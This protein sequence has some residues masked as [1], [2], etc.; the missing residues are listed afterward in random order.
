M[1]F[2]SGTIE[3][4]SEPSAS[5]QQGTKRGTDKTPK[6]AKKVRWNDKEDSDSEESDSSEDEITPSKT[7]QQDVDVKK[8]SSKENDFEV[9][10]VEDNSEFNREGNQVCEVHFIVK[11]ALPF[12]LDRVFDY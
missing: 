7:K 8:G 1:L 11:S 9:V 2:L 4:N 6:E 10:P 12:P 5:V 3:K